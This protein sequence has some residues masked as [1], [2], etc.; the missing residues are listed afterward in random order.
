MSAM[1]SAWNV[2]SAM[3][4]IDIYKKFFKP[5]A[6]EKE[7]LLVG[8]IT[9]IFLAF[10]AII[11]AL[12]IIH[13]EYGVFTVSNII[14]G[15]IGIPVTIPLFVGVLSKSVSRWSAIS[16]VL[17]GTVVASLSRFVLN[18]NLGPQY[19]IITIVTL[20]FVFLSKPLGKLYNQNKKMVL[21]VNVSMGILFY[22]FFMN[23]NTNPNLIISR[24]NHFHIWSILASLVLFLISHKF[25]ELFGKDLNTDR[26][27][28]DQFFTDLDTPIN[29]QEEVMS[30][31]TEEFNAFPL[32]GK[33][34]FAIAIISVIMYFFPGGDSNIWVNI[35]ISSLMVL[36]GSMMFIFNKQQKNKIG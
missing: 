29:V 6:T 13:S 36:T 14:L 24:L 28:I 31:T 5:N 35:S 7:T 34:A 3:V 25:S 22:L 17:A 27:E 30:D 16:S 18:Y 32:V 2:V 9:I 10:I 11:M 15:L 19:I 12:F 26:K 23:F 8:R 33:I 1:D 21:F 20:L 4:S